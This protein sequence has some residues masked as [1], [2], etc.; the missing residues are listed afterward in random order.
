MDIQVYYTHGL[1]GLDGQRPHRTLNLVQH[2]QQRKGDK[3]HNSAPTS[4][5]CELHSRREAWRVA[6]FLHQLCQYILEQDQEALHAR[7]FSNPGSKRTTVKNLSHERDSTTVLLDQMKVPNLAEKNWATTG[8]IA[9]DRNR[10]DQDTRRV[11][12]HSHGI[13]SNN[14]I[15]KDINTG[16]LEHWDN[17]GE[18]TALIGGKPIHQGIPHNFALGDCKGD[19]QHAS[20]V[21]QGSAKGNSKGWNQQRQGRDKENFLQAPHREVVR[22]AI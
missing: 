7:S 9:T 8:S 19:V 6:A 11:P 1:D 14:S 21:R 16:I 15:R 13:Q 18:G 22:G 10:K 3:W 12:D 5:T 20:T 17:F 2:L 4:N